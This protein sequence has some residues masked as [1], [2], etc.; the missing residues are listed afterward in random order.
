MLRFG[1]C[2]G[3]ACLAFVPCSARA[4]APP[5]RANDLATAAHVAASVGEYAFAIQAL[6]EASRISA[7]PELLFALGE[8][9]RE[10]FALDHRPADERAAIDAYHRYL[11]A[12]PE[13][14]HAADATRSLAKLADASSNE[15]PS[16]ETPSSE[17]NAQPEAA[18]PARLAVTSPIARAHMRIDGGDE[19]ALPAFVDLAPGEHLVTVTAKG[20]WPGLAAVH[21]AR[22]GVATVD[23]TLDPA[24]ARIV[25]PPPSSGEVYVDGV[26]VGT[27]PLDHPVD[28]DP[29]HHSVTLATNG[30]HAYSEDV[31]VARGETRTVSHVLTGTH[32]R[33]AAYALIGLG[34][35][36]IAI[37]IGLGVAA[38]VKD[39]AASA[40]SARPNMMLSASDQAR[41]DSLTSARDSFRLGAAIS[42]G[43]GLVITVVGGGLFAFDT[44]SLQTKPKS[45]GLEFLAPAI[46]P[47]RY[48][49]A[50]RFFC[51]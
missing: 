4:D 11:Q 40:I 2:F 32:Q 21:V 14:G 41:Y 33:T 6:E 38:V 26:S 25:V 10:R 37:G 39:R 9:H 31:H 20:Y 42:A 44:P 12:T 29:G 16:T 49:A 43:A 48:G 8:A 27:A 47:G 36:G 30:H 23:V 17:T 50:A 19:K 7:D 3:A 24:A 46:S 45:A 5:D 13:G 28:V 15:T 18:P 34:G 35:A 22:S 1:V 51:R